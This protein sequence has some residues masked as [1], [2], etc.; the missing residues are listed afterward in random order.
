M[1]TVKTGGP[2]QP[3]SIT[4][5]EKIYSSVK[6]SMQNPEVKRH[7]VNN[8]VNIIKKN[9][10]NKIEPLSKD[11]KN[12]GNNIVSCILEYPKVIVEHDYDFADG[13]P[14]MSDDFKEVSNIKLPFPKLVIITGGRINESAVETSSSRG[15]KMLYCYFLIQQES[16]IEVHMLCGTSEYFSNPNKILYIESAHIYHNGHEIKTVV[17]QNKLQS[18]VVQCTRSALTV[19]HKM[20]M[21]K[22][23]FYMSVPTPE[24]TKA[25][26]KRINK[27]KKPLIR[28]ETAVIEGKK[29]MMSST[30]HGTHASPCLHWRRGHWR[31]ISKSG[32]KIWIDP[33]EVGD[34]ANGKIIKTYAI[35]KYSLLEAR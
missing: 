31:T 4:T 30:G 1:E 3:I 28:F 18:S 14:Q 21:S 15:I 26:R 35:G 34:E 7:V 17:Y 25:N 12:V 16:G 8:F 10:N 22:N 27:G 2:L 24:E 9:I 19:I 23:K 29:T 11:L 5:T 32:K 6:E 33:M 13:I 20:T